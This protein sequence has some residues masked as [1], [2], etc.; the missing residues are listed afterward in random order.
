[1]RSLTSYNDWEGLVYSY[2][3]IGGLA[4]DEL[5]P[6]KTFMEEEIIHDPSG[7]FPY[8]VSI[9]CDNS[10]SV[11][12]GGSKL[13]TFRINNLGSM[14]DTYSLSLESKKGWG[15]FDAIPEQITV[16]PGES[17]EL[18]ITVEIPGD[19]YLMD[20]D[21]IWLYV[22]SK[23][24]PNMGVSG[25]VN[26][27]A[28]ENNSPVVDAGLDL[29]V[30]EGEVALLSGSFTDSDF[31]DTHTVQIDWNDGQ[32][33]GVPIGVG[34]IISSSHLYQEAG[35]YTAIVSV[36][37][38]KGGTGTDSIQVTVIPDRDRDGVIDSEDAFPDDP[39]EWLDTDSD[40]IGNN[41]DTDDDNDGMPDDYENANGFDPL[42]PADAQQDKDNDGFTNI[43]EYLYGSDPADSSSIPIQCATTVPDD[44]TRIQDAANYV[45][46]TDFGGNV[47]V[48]PGTY[49]EPKLK[50]Q[51]GVYL[52]ALSN[53]PAATIIDGNGK[54]DVITFQG[55][56]VG[57]VVGF[58]LRN[59][60]K[61]GNA[62]AINIAGAKQMPLIV[63][64]IITDNRHGIRLQGNVMPLLINNTIADNKGDGIS[65]GGNSPAT[66]I[67]NIVVNNKGDGIVSKGKAIDE[68][69]HND[70]Y[71]NKGGNYV[72]ITAG[73]G[74]ISL[75]P[76][77]TEGYQLA[78]D[79]PCIGTGLTLAGEA[80]DMGA[81]GN[82][83][84][85]LINETATAMFSDSDKDGIDDAWE[86]LFFGNLSTADSTSDFDQDGYSDMQEYQNNLHH[87]VDPEGNSFDLTGKNE[88]N[89][90]GYVSGTK[91]QNN[92]IYAIIQLLLGKEKEP[93][94]TR[95]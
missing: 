7:I 59:S 54:D 55:V 62:A 20:K 22:D 72:R 65:A 26:I 95:P 3:S 64:N 80:V 78:S 60:K 58:T 35:T 6:Q 45:A 34:N 9:Q 42:Y 73:E 70:V 56:R 40:G 14:P 85:R 8:D 93:E 82:S 83:S 75:D 18:E 87:Q 50:L 25:F 69:A 74:G 48:Q 91:V 66:V 10:Q 29:T 79:S 47:C 4:V 57:G 39:T 33:E 51:D 30:Y 13:Y 53:D 31:Q 94:T 41:A 5:T 43:E 28:V 23:M 81:Y 36:T 37:D 88:P 89:G 11:G 44:F 1:M 17:I 90:Q 61:N 46:I 16:S 21:V 49:V 84:A 63:R 77:F 76:R 32:I 38:D 68:L 15:K 27:I 24:N 92:F 71:N 2:G 52:V 67:N 19:T 12:I 86:L